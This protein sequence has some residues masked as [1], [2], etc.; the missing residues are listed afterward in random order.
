MSSDDHLDAQ[1]LRDGGPAPCN[2]ADLASLKLRYWNSGIILLRAAALV[3][4]AT[5]ATQLCSVWTWRLWRRNPWRPNSIG[6][7]D[8]IKDM[9]GGDADTP[10]VPPK[11]FALVWTIEL[12]TAFVFAIC[13]FN[14]SYLD[15]NDTGLLDS[16]H[17]V[18]ILFAPSAEA[19]TEA[20]G[21]L[22]RLT[23]PR[24]LWARASVCVC[25][26]L[27]CALMAGAIL[28]HIKQ[29]HNFMESVCA[30]SV[31]AQSV[32]VLAI[33]IVVG[34]SILKDRKHR[35]EREHRAAHPTSAN[36]HRGDCDEAD[37]I[38]LKVGHL[39]TGGDPEHGALLA[40]SLWLL[41]CQNFVAAGV[42][43]LCTAMVMWTIYHGLYARLWDLLFGNGEAAAAYQQ[44][45]QL[46]SS[47]TPSRDVPRERRVPPDEDTERD[48]G[49]D[50]RAHRTPEKTRLK[51]A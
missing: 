24:P 6:F 11:L 19:Q 37:A 15:L 10:P 49:T 51:D 27:E 22:A 8:R 28:T 29:R 45:V 18:S 14:F 47:R 32:A 39:L 7:L 30:W 42:F 36:F 46:V 26:L 9:L 43:I 16:Q 48:T 31:M 40:W 38:E 20:A 4:E 35:L 1:Q 33:E 12:G 21:E 41:T 3:F 34:L 17:Q 2:A 23:T 25:C 44:V 5:L 13:M 50:Y